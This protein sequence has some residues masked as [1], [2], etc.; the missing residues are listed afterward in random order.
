M[1]LLNDSNSVIF[2]NESSGD[3]SSAFTLWNPF[4]LRPE[5]GS[6]IV[7]TIILIALLIY[8]NIS[9]KKLDPKNPPKGI[10]F[11]IFSLIGTFKNL[12]Y[13]SLG[14]EFVKITPY[15]LTFFS[16]I[17][18]CN[19]ISVIGYENPTSLTTVTFS[20]G[21]NT[22]IGMIII[23]IKYQKSSF[24]YRFLFK[25]YVPTKK[26][27]KIMVPYCFNPF[28]VLDLITPWISMSLRLWANIMAGALIIGL[29]YA[30]PMVFFRH[31]PTSTDPKPEIILFSFFAIPLHGFLDWLIGGIQ[32]Y[33]FIVLTLC[34]WNTC[35]EIED[36]NYLEKIKKKNALA[37]LIESA[38][39]R[40]QENV[41]L[42]NSGRVD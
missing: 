13:E 25:F 16:Y 10:A 32:A 7:V 36:E 20:L 19:I 26:G 15:F 3:D 2:A 29:F 42:I 21:I 39:K 22:T 6:I 28:G 5:I 35:T 1:I 14:K 12:V 30:L 31:N 8:Y 41:T 33:V 9:M 27:N 18:L 4:E 38:D 24:F 40:N 34:Y 11:F 23:G 37:K 17:L